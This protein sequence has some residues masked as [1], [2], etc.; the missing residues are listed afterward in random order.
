MNK[1]GILLVVLFLLLCPLIYAEINDDFN[2][3]LETVQGF[4]SS[5]GI[6]ES[7]TA[8]F[9]RIAIIILVTFILYEIL[10]H[11][12]VRPGTSGVI[13][14]VLSS[15][16]VIVIPSEVLLGIAASYGTLFMF[17]LFGGPIAGLFFLVYVI[18]PGNSL[19]WRGVRIVILIMALILEGIIIKW[20]NSL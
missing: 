5:L 8:T 14:F 17:I 18:I 15:I 2:S 16:S 3:F 11:V 10:S 7:P 6:N 9:I 12:G 19:V 1:K 20:L 4:N 13:A